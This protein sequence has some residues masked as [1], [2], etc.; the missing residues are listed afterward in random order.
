MKHGLRSSLAEL[1]CVLSLTVSAA[2][3]TPDDSA[4]RELERPSS[5]GSDTQP[6]MLDAAQEPSAV[7][8]DTPPVPST[9]AGSMIMPDAGPP[10]TDVAPAPV[11]VGAG[12]IAHCASPHDEETSKLLDGIAGTVFVLGDNV[13][14]SGS[15]DEFKNCYEPS[16][17]RHKARTRPV[18]GNHEYNTPS[19]APYYA[20]FGESAGAA[21]KG[22]YSYDLGAW[23]IVALNTN[24][25]M[26][27]PS[28]QSKWLAADLAAH[29]SKCTLAY[30]HYPLFSSG[31][32]GDIA[33]VKDLWKV[34]HERGVDVVLAGHDHHYER[35]APQDP[36]GKADPAGIREFVVGTGGKSLRAATGKTNTEVVNGDTYG[37]LKLTLHPTS[38]DWSFIPVEGA[39][40]TDQGSANCH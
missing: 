1:S 27:P 6:P 25:S 15:A 10:P 22:Y 2:C 5:A 39:K 37:V 21:G 20:Y 14:E 7:D 8:A 13:Y 38:Y 12:D 31:E 32:H 35:F 4:T 16:W 28:E 18:V 33:S 40:F 30:M 3:S 17:G 19:A 9:D 26:G 24:I 11:M 23:H 36:D 29:D 34:L